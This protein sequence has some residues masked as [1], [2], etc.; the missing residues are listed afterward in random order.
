MKVV[1]TVVASASWMWIILARLPLSLDLLAVGLA[2][3]N[4]HAAP[5]TDT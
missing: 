5:C 1:R 4:A 3:S 2:A